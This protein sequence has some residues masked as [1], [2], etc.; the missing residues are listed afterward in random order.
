MCRYSRSH[1]TYNFGEGRKNPDKVRQKYLDQFFGATAIAQSAFRALRNPLFSFALR[2]YLNLAFSQEDMSK[3][4]SKM[5]I[6]EIRDTLLSEPWLHAKIFRDICSLFFTSIGWTTYY[7]WWAVFNESFFQCKMYLFMILIICVPTTSMTVLVFVWH[8]W[9][10][11]YY[12]WK[13]SIQQPI[14]AG[15]RKKRSALNEETHKANAE[16]FMEEIYQKAVAALAELA[17]RRDSNKRLL[18]AS[19]AL[20]Y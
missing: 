11:Y 13:W 18:H 1:K 15:K 3:I 12:R 20:S 16:K 8:L 6:S 4:L 19:V 5:H 10:V 9:L 7:V 2:T 17:N 14:I